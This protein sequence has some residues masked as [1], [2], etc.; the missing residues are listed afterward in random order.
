MELRPIKGRAKLPRQCAFRVIAVATQIP[1]RD[2]AAQSQDG[3]KQSF[4]KLVLGLTQPG[5]LLEDGG[6]NCH[7]DDPLSVVLILP[8]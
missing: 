8:Q 2:V 1:K 6:D 5:H 7:G 3:G 4:Q